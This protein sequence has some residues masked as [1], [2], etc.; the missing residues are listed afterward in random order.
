MIHKKRKSK[1]VKVP[2]VL[3]S[4]INLECKYLKKIDLKSYPKSIHQSKI[5]IG[6]V[7]GIYINDKYIKDGKINSV[8]MNAISRMGYNEYA[9]INS[10][11]LEE[12]A[13]HLAISSRVN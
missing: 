4:P 1:I 11:L 3:E 9:E 5:I 6:E 8:K 10:K 13:S 7:V 2:S 12:S